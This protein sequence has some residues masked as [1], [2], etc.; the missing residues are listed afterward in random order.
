MKWLNALL[1]FLPRVSRMR[2]DL[3]IEAWYRSRTVI[4]NLLTLTGDVLSYFW[5]PSYGIT[6]DETSAVAVGIVAIGNIVMRFISG[7][8]I[9]LRDVS[10]T[11]AE[12]GETDHN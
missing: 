4:T 5:G 3:A 9:G 2:D 1:K 10:K 8:R 7:R 6:V 11:N 12:S